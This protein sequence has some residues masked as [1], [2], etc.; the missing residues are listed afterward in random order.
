MTESKKETALIELVEEATAIDAGVFVL[1]C[2][3]D[4]FEKDAATGYS[5]Q[6]RFYAP[7]N[8]KPRDFANAV[9]MFL[10]EI[11]YHTDL[12]VGQMVKLVNEEIAEFLELAE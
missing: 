4:G 5:G 2:E 3:A 7:N 11:C 1:T 9:A 12:P 10:N 8:W 6:M